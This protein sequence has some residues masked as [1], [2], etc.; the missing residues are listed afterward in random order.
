M[1]G[2]VVIAAGESRRM[3]RNKLLIEIGGKTIIE[4][5]VSSFQG[6]ADETIVV[7]GYKPE[8]TAPVLE[9]LGIKWVVNVNYA[10][11][12]ATSFKRGLKEL[13]KCEAVFLAL[14]DQ[15]FIGED[16]LRGAVEA[17][18]SGAKIV[19]PVHAG[20]KG[21]PVLFDKS[22]FGEIFSLKRHETVRDVI[23]RHGDKHILLE[24][25]AWAVTDVDSPED[26]E[27]LGN[28]SP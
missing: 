2:A 26:L 28:F 27:K 13:E 18:K 5:V 19:S 25:G 22:L 21:H 11:G 16:F 12:M 4:R 23:H 3:G 14:G 7:L 8:Q 1:I 15:P 6:L 17:W 24:A 20:K 10:D 9:K